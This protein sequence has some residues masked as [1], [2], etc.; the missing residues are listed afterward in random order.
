MPILNASD[1]RSI[2]TERARIE[3]KTS[4]AVMLED[5]RARAT[6]DV[7]LSHSFEDAALVLGLKTVIERSRFTVYVDW[8][9]DPQL[10][11]SHVTPATANLLRARMRSCRSLLYAATDNAPQSKW[12]P[13]ELGYFDG[14]RQGLVAILPVVRDGAV[15]F[16]GQEYLGLYPHVDRPVT[17]GLQLRRGPTLIPLREWISSAPSTARLY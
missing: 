10:T 14:L 16:H 9:D 13:W 8:I 1:L 12:M 3:R 6:F 11:R 5:N 7:F 15:A 2:G 4:A 17:G